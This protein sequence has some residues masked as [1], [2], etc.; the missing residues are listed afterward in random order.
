MYFFHYQRFRGQ[1]KELEEAL[2]IANEDLIKEKELNAKN[3]EKLALLEEQ[4]KQVEVYPLS[5]GVGSTR[6]GRHRGL[7]IGSVLRKIPQVVRFDFCRLETKLKELETLLGTT[8]QEL[9][10]EKAASVKHEQDLG[11]LREQHESYHT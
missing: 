4:S 10:T 7:G 3:V 9:A 11:G 1:L 2:H 6:G 5:F 8:K